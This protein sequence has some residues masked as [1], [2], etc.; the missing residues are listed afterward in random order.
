MTQPTT[1]V[2]ERDTLFT[3][4]GATATR[5]QAQILGEKGERA[6]AQAR[7]VLAELRRRA[8]QPIDQDPLSLEKTLLVLSPALNENS[9]GRGDVP[10]PSE[11]AAFHA[12]TLFALHMQ[13]STRPM[14]VRGISF[15]TACGRLYAQSDS[16][17]LKPRFDA[18]L[19]ARS[20]RARLAHTRSMVTLLRGAGLGFDYAQFAND[21]R[22]LDS[23]DKRSGILLR[24]GR[25]FAMGRFQVSESA[26]SSDNN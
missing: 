16:G 11:A 10:S 5:L 14:H 4:V 9:I 2:A 22:T 8:G 21:L 6:Q 13:S 25:D 3:S 15:A 1:E 19:L 24:W 7:G 17:S 26:N 23:A 18:L 12:L 20:S